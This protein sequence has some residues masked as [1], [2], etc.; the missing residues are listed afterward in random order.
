[1]VHTKDERGVEKV[2]SPWMVRTPA[3][4][5]RPGKPRDRFSAGYVRHQAEYPGA[6]ARDGVR[7]QVVGG[8]VLG[9]RHRKHDLEDLDGR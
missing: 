4:L 2:G 1:V 6:C 3:T 7:T 5:E 8:R 9:G